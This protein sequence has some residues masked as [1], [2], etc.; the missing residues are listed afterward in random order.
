MLLFA[1]GRGARRRFDRRIA[2]TARSGPMGAVIAPSRSRR[3]CGAAV[4]TVS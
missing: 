2:R 1:G 4:V 3:T